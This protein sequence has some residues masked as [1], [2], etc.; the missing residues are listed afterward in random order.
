MVRRKQVGEGLIS[1]ILVMALAM[2]STVIFLDVISRVTSLAK[3]KR[4]AEQLARGADALQSLLRKHGASIIKT[5]TASGFANPLKPTFAELK[6]GLYLPRVMRPITPFNGTLDFTIRR[7]TKND[8][9]GLV[10]DT[11]SVT[12]RGSPSPQLAS[13]VMMA[14]NGVGLRTSIATPTI[15]SG[16]AFSGV[17]SPIAGPAIVCAWAYIGAP[18]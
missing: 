17:Q 6:A 1:L 7:G 12:E 11:Q 2:A 15:L 13:E 8:L 18:T 5:G 10:C 16:Q 3:A 9:F 4:E 14:A